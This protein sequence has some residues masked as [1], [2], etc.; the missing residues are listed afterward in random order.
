[1]DMMEFMGGQGWG[2]RNRDGEKILKFA[3]SF[4]MMIGNTFFKKD[5]EKLIT[6]KSR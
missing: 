1:M 2:K 6:F 4:D 3:D 5:A